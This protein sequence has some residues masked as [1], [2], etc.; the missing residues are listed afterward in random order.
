MARGT[1]VLDKGNTARK[2]L[3]DQTL[4]AFV[5]TVAFVAGMATFKGKNIAGVR[6]DVERV[7]FVV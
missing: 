6:R 7:S 5:N 4:G 3:F 2:L 1:T